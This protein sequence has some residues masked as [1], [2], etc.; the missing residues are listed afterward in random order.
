MNDPLLKISG[1]AVGYE[2]KQLLS[3]LDLEVQRGELV[4]ILGANGVGKSTLL[5][6]ITGVDKPKRGEILIDGRKVGDMKLRERARCVSV[7]TTVASNGG[8]LTVNE[9]VALGRQ[10][11]TGF[12]GRLSASDRKAVANAIETLGLQALEERQLGTLSDGER[13]KVM[14]ARAL[15]QN[16]PLMVL[17]EPTS[18]LDVASRVEVLQILKRLAH[19]GGVGVLLSCHD[20]ATALRLADRVWLAGDGGIKANRPSA[21]VAEGW[22]DRLFADRAV[23]FDASIGDFLPKDKL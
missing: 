10:P 15:A 14:I 8:G 12:L 5:R 20:V 7:V 3:G 11:Y 6:C 21:A 18:Y 16:A 2:G 13:Q 19:E 9:A 22:L 23:R 1:V 17:D 4:A